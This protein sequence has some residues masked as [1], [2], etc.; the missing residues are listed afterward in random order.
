M[1]SQL[2]DSILLIALFIGIWYAWF[3]EYRS[4]LND[5]TRQRLFD[6]RDQLFNA[7]EAGEI[8]FDNEL[9][10]IT[11]TTLNGVIRYTHQLS[12]MHFILTLFLGRNDIKNSPQ[13][14]RYQERWEDAFLKTESEHQKKLI[15]KAQKEMHLTVFYHIV[16]GSL[17]LRAV[18]Y[19][20]ALLLILKNRKIDNAVTSKSVRSKWTMLDAEANCIGQAVA[21]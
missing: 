7:A 20:T 19:M 18:L 12:A 11:R 2:N 17:F 21:S 16:R 1:D 15:L 5:S 6:I 13:L 14:K 10:C 3:V 4:Y 8:D 9:Y